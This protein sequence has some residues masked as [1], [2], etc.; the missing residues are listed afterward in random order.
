MTPAPTADPAASVALRHLKPAQIAAHP[1]NPRADVGDVTELADSIRSVGILEP[2]VVAPATDKAGDIVPEKF[3]LI[4]GHR[5][6][7]AARLAKAKTVPALVRTDLAGDDVAQLAAMLVEN[8]QR[9]DLTPIEEGAGYQALL[10]FPGWTAAKIAT[11][12]GRSR[13]TIRARVALAGLPEP[14]QAR[15]H[16]GQITIDQASELVRYAKDP[17][18]LAKLEK[19]AGTPDWSY[20][21]TR[22]KDDAS[23]ARAVAKALATLAADSP[24]VRVLSGSDLPTGWRWSA[25]AAISALAGFSPPLDPV[26]HAETCPG[27]AVAVEASVEWRGSRAVHLVR[28]EPVCTTPAAHAEDTDPASVAAA[29]AE[30]AEKAAEAELL[31]QLAPAATLRREHLADCLAHGTGAHPT[32]LD[33]AREILVRAGR[34]HPLLGYAAQLLRVPEEDLDASLEELDLGQ[35]VVLADLLQEHGAEEGLAKHVHAWGSRSWTSGYRGRLGTVYG[36]SWTPAERAAMDRCA[37]AAADDDDGI[38]TV[39][40]AGD[41]DDE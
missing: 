10:E 28:P 24:D 41:L 19:A 2:L 6:L 4:A 17:K 33:R 13:A 1:R 29:A 14:T 20:T 15:I 38:V 12:T 40:D 7:A 23:K 36:W 16:T 5:R 32:A 18:A 26:V 11:T 3:R 9:V 34:P 8:L 31:D 22:V 21:L 27:H 30:A 35:L 37:A 25:T 39:D